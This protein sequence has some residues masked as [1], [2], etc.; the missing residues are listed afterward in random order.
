M[1]SFGCVLFLLLTGHRL[2]QHTKDPIFRG[3]SE[4]LPAW[5]TRLEELGVRCSPQLM[6]FMAS[7]FQPRP[8]SRLTVE[9]ALRH[10]WLN[11][12]EEDHVPV[13]N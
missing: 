4:G 1:W 12:D 2:Y 13:S 5:R 6:D 9:E 7:V 10:E 8:S 11:G 3:M